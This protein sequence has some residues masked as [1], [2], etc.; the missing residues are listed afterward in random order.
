MLY[1]AEE[2]EQQEEE[3]EDEDPEYGWLCVFAY[4]PITTASCQ[5]F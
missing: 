4:R 3:E 5:T 2:Q 1:T